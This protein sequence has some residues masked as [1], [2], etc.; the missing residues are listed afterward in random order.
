MAIHRPDSD[1]HKCGVFQYKIVCA[2]T[3]ICAEFVVCG[4]MFY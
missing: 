4:G 1:Y 2:Y 3:Q